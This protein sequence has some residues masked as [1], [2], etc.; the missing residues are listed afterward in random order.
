M[1]MLRWWPALSSWGAGLI[2]FSVSAQ[3]PLAVGIASAAIAI[4]AFGWGAAALRRDAPPVPRV[5]LAVAMGVLIA[6]VALVM[7]GGIGWLG[8][9][10]LSAL[11]LIVAASAAVVL[12]RGSEDAPASRRAHRSSG[13]VALV[14]GAL[15]VAAV[16]TP[17]LAS[18]EAGELAV[19]HGEL[20]GVH[21]H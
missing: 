19:P 7:T 12:R 13:T 18:S 9:L 2:L 5:A 6:G 11:V 4:A 15:L 14:T 16:T 10:A 8:W 20:H 21:T 1:M 3:S 17:A